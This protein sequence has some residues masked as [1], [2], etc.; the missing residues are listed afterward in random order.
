MNIAVWRIAAEENIASAN[1]MNGAGAQVTGGRW[2]SPGTHLINPLHPDTND[3]VATT[4]RK[5]SYDHR[6]F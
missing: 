2:N 3:I 4:V 6:F 5:W 1:D